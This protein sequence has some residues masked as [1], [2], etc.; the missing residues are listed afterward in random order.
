MLERGA[1]APFDH[2]QRRPKRTESIASHAERDR[3]QLAGSPIR[4]GYCGNQSSVRPEN[5]PWLPK[6]NP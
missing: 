3:D 4:P 2:C 5:D 1:A 6:P